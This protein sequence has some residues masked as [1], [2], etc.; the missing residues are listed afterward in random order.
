MRLPAAA[1]EA[2]LPRARAPRRGWRRPSLALASARAARRTGA[3]RKG[4]GGVVGVGTQHARCGPRAPLA[5]PKVRVPPGERAKVK[6]N[7]DGLRSALGGRTKLRIQPG[8]PAAG[9]PLRRTVAGRGLLHGPVDRE[10]ARGIEGVEGAE[11]AAAGRRLTRPPV[12]RLPART[13]LN[14]HCAQQRTTRH[15]P[16]SGVQR[17]NERYVSL[18]PTGASHVRGAAAAISPLP[19]RRARVRRSEA[20]LR[21]SSPGGAPGWR[22]WGPL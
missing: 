14:R 22:R 10:R 17:D 20:T 8:V 12:R 18:S 16:P 19:A 2:L 15:T 13:H 5:R 21:Q 1:V 7:H 4:M 3:P 11:E 9:A 6:M